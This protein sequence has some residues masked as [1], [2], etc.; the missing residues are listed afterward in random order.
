MSENDASTPR[1]IQTTEAFEALVL[2][3]REQSRIAVDTESNS[4]HAYRE[5]VCL[6]AVLH[7]PT[8]LCAGP[9]GA[10]R[11]SLRWDR[12]FED[13]GIEKIFHAAEYDILCL[14]RDYGFGF[15]N[16]FDTMQAGR[17]LGRKLAGLDRLL[18]EKFGLKVSKRLQKADWG[19]RPLSPELL[20]YAAQDTHYLIP[21]RDLLESE[22]REKGLLEL[23]QEDFRMACDHQ[24]PAGSG[25]PRITILGAPACAT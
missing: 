4:L 14:R 10:G 1:L 11:I 16:I 6:T 17:I 21:L 2:D 12:C 13:P 23:A 3:L 5:R 8:G 24:Q 18:E 7:R 22:L 20:Q 25:A 15:V 19:A 9:A